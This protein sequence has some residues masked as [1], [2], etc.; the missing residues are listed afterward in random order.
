M[1]LLQYS[2]DLIN[3]G[4][5]SGDPLQRTGSTLGHVT[6]LTL[7]NLGESK[8]KICEH[9]IYF[10]FYYCRGIWNVPFIGTAI[11]FQGEWL[12]KRSTDAKGLPSFAS[13]EYEPDMAF[14]QWM[15]NNVSCIVTFYSYITLYSIF[16]D[17]CSYRVTSC[18]SVT[19]KSMAISL[20]LQTMKF[21]IFT[22]TFI[23]SLKTDL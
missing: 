4:Q 11:L 6:I 9:E 19:F 20:V 23:T 3:T 7:L 21:I 2:D 22:M 14:C 8:M 18:M 12:I 13:A 16:C 17:S 1:L 10:S 5:I 15:R